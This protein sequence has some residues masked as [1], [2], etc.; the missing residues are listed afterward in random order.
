MQYDTSSD[1]V[2]VDLTFEIRSDNRVLRTATKR[3]KSINEKHARRVGKKRSYKRISI[4][5]FIRSDL[6]FPPDSNLFRF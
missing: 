5:V 3:M 6:F 1:V 2:I 4:L